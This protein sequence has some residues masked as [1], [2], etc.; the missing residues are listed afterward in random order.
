MNEPVFCSTK[1]QKRIAP[2]PP[3]RRLWGNPVQPKAES[4]S[5]LARQVAD[6]GSI[7]IQSAWANCAAE[8]ARRIALARYT[9][10]SGDAAADGAALR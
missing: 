9:T 8:C 2:E 6:I 5:A 7:Q 1:T 3:M 10:R 4:A